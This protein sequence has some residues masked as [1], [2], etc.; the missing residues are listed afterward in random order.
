MEVTYL[1]L[2]LLVVVATESCLDIDPTKIPAPPEEGDIVE[3]ICGK[4]RRDGFV[5][6]KYQCDL[7]Y[8][9]KNKIATARYCDE[10]F[11]FDDSKTNAEK[12]KK[13]QEVDCGDRCFVQES[14][15]DVHARCVKTNGI[16]NF[17]DE[18]GIEV[19]VCDKYIECVHNVPYERPCATGTLFDEIKGDCVRPD[20][21]SPGARVCKT[22]DLV[23]ESLSID[24][25]TCPKESVTFNGL[26]Q[27][28]PLY[29]HPSPD[30][31]TRCQYYFV[32]YFNKKPNKFGCTCPKVFNPDLNRC[33]EKKDGPEECRDVVCN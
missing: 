6:D 22:S 20:E 29:P 31:K 3:N 11:L 18:D 10:G 24:G 15:T 1:F 27:E 14:P 5:R 28:H 8:H 26:S 12:C 13:S 7:Y 2:S 21:R 17:V 33:V 16:F 9:C 25:F 4:R 19:N 32:C 30:L 23:D